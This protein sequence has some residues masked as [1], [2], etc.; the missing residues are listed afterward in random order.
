MTSAMPLNYEAIRGVRVI[1]E[2][3]KARANVKSVNK[4]I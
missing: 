2:S 1:Y 4:G 3:L